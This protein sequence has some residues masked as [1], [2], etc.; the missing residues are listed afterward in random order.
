MTA[1][2]T[3]WT[4][5]SSMSV[6][7]WGRTLGTATINST[8]AFSLPFTVPSD[9]APGAEQLMFSPTCM[10][11][12]VAPF[13][14]FTVDPP[15][16]TGMSVPA[17]P[18]NLTVTAVDQH[19][20]RLNWQDNSSN[21]TG[22]EINNGVV[23]KNAGAN[24]TT[25][26]WGGLAPGTYM[27]FKIRAYNSAGDSAWDPNVS[28]YYVCTTTPKP[29]GASVPA[30]P[31][32]LTV[33]AVDQHDIR[34]N[35]QD[36]S[37]NETG[38]EINNGVVSKNAG[39]NSTTYTWGGLAPG[40]YMCFKIRAYN[41]AGDSAWDPNVSPYYVCTT[42]PKP[43]G[44]SV[45][46]APSNLTVTAVDQHDIRLNWQ[47]N[48][49]NETG[50]EINNGVVSKNAGANSTTYT[51]GGLAHGTYMCFKIR[52]YNS[53]GDSPWDPNVSP[54][55]V[56]TT[57][58]KPV[59]E[60][61]YYAALGDSYSAGLGNSPP[62]PNGLNGCG[63]SVKA[64]PALLDAD[65]PTL[66]KLGFIACA[67]DVTDDF[68]TI[69]ANL[70]QL[71]SLALL[72]NVRSVTLTIGGNDIGFASVAKA[73]LNQTKDCYK[74]QQSALNAR[75]N[76]LAGKGKATTPEGRPIHALATLLVDIHKE[77]P[78]ARIFLLGYPRLFGTDPKY[79]SIEKYHNAPSALV[80]HLPTDVVLGNFAIRYDDAQWFNQI[81]DRLNG[82]LASAVA[83][84]GVPA[85]FVSVRAAF[86]THGYCDS[87]PSWFTPV[88][89]LSFHPGSSTLHPNSNGQRAYERDLRSAE[90]V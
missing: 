58:P 47:D 23:S 87:G 25:Y 30:A 50:F 17:A 43:P 48:S 12:T 51:W 70:S 63:Q 78:Q 20:I 72:S 68:Y 90:G 37:S 62:Y 6:S 31:S 60:I 45:P 56:C 66:G 40:T 82:V 61:K 16:G 73:C 4:G 39:A 7:G 29:P 44:A 84:A 80:C 14:T 79:Y 85:S 83:K 32:N 41:S 59:Q 8:G 75:I 2:A 38:F 86:T 46:A 1:L 21:E 15:T 77:A 53:A 81:A 11:S 19:D 24:S 67:G 89:L 36:N 10:H 34:L 33:T 26:T 54:Y 35:W 27:C 71:A 88:N 76:A 28:P 65:V 9:A 57:T 42:T 22:F 64:Y 13:V 5:C 52:A 55:Y 74:A 69:G 3:D 18:S 49:S